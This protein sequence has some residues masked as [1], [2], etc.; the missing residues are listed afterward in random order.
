MTAIF[1]LFFTYNKQ[2][3]KQQRLIDLLIN[4]KKKLRYFQQIR[5]N[6]KENVDNEA[7]IFVYIF[8]LLLIRIT[9]MLIRKKF[10]EQKFLVISSPENPATNCGYHFFRADWWLNFVTIFQIKISKFVG[11]KNY[12]CKAL[13]LFSDL[14][15]QTKSMSRGLNFYSV[16]PICRN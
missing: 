13:A 12:Y 8:I 9:K 14:L 1:L 6:W 5:E 10:N 3:K 11:E 2:V 16:F 7:K 4:S 15:P